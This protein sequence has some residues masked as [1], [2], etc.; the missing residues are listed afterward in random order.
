MK[1]RGCRAF[2]RHD[3]LTGDAELGAVIYPRILSP[4]PLSDLDA[5]LRVEIK[6]LHQRLGAAMISKPTPVR[7]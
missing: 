4:W 2:A 3:G 5:Q 6:R 7:L 1:R